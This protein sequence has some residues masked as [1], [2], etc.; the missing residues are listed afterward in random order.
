MFRQDQVQGNGFQRQLAQGY[1]LA[2]LLLLYV[3][4]NTELCGW[5]VKTPTCDLRGIPYLREYPINYTPA[6]LIC[7]VL[8]Q[9]TL[10]SYNV[11]LF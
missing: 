9:I 5:P 7:A 8:F 10:S 6:A 2:A 4:H 11:N 1:C 3:R